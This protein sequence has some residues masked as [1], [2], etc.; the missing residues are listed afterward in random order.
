M[1]EPDAGSVAT[2]VLYE[3]L[4]SLSPEH[5]SAIVQAYYVEASSEQTP[6]GGRMSDSAVKARLHDALRALHVVA[7]NSGILS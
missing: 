1:T 4:R 3:A 2:T 7:M 6:S 5:R